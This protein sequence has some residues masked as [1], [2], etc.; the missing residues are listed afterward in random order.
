M[1][2]KFKLDNQ[3]KV[4]TNWKETV[5]FS[6][7]PHNIKEQL[8]DKQDEFKATIFNIFTLLEGINNNNKID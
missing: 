8:K 2:F 3:K 4:L 5:E 6:K 1:K 7:K